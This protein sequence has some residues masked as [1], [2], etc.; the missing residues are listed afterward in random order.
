MP[1]AKVIP[2]REDIFTLKIALK[3]SRPPIWRRV[4]VPKSASLYILH[5]VIQIA[6]EWNGSHLW[7][8]E[9]K[10]IRYGDRSPEFDDI[11]GVDLPNDAGET[12]LSSIFTRVGTKLL[13]TYDFGDN[14]EH[15]IVLE[16]KERRDPKV[17]YPRCIGGKRAAPPDDCGGISGYYHMLNVLQHPKCD[18]YE[19]VMYWL[20]KDFDR[21][22]FDI[23]EINE[24]LI[25]HVQIK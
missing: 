1:P 13:Y 20:G 21:K 23:D 8:F 11:N 10:G 14:W 15:E 4:E 25:Q 7:E 24:E 22:R 9:K 17:A 18:E 5:K 12:S 19:D 16:K 3:Y 2:I 6:F